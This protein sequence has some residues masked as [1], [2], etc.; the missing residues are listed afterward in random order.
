MDLNGGAPHTDAEEMPTTAAALGVI[1]ETERRSMMCAQLAVW[2]P[3]CSAD[4]IAEAFH[5]AYQRAAAGDCDATSVGQVY[6]WLRITA[7]RY[8]QRQHDLLRFELPVAPDSKPLQVERYDA[9]PFEQLAE[10]EDDRDL[11][12]LAERVVARLSDRQQ[13][14]FAL[15]LAGGTRSEIA[16]QLG[17]RA[18]V[19]KRD[20]ERISTVARSE[21]ANMAGGGC[22]DG[23]TPVM[24]L[25]YGLAETE[26]AA[27][28]RTHMARCRDCTN[29]YEQLDL[30][31][32]KAA[33]IL[34]APAAE[35]AAPGL[36]ERTVYGATDGAARAKQHVADAAS[37]LRNGI[38]DGGAQVKQQ[39]ASAYYRAV[40]P[41]P[42]AGVRP[43]AAA[44]VI[45]GCLAI[46][47]GAAT[48]CASEDFDPFG[49]GIGLVKPAPD[50]E[51]PTDR[52]PSAKDRSDPAETVAAPVPT[53]AP[54]PAPA[55]PAADPAPDPQAE[56]EAEVVP[57]TAEPQP[58][59]PSGSD[60]LSGLTGNPT[61]A[62]APAPPPAP[63]VSGNGGGG[64]GSAGTDFGGL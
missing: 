35:T 39:A 48:Y 55:A 32:Q 60:S 50:H 56:T 8:L 31:R 24:R 64:S 4:E 26:Q 21:L 30:W 13:R 18:R 47:G 45:V 11:A 6:R 59:P 34:P 28:A 46:G 51:K 58:V 63:T 43:G 42:L 27:E 3:Q 2:H 54:D 40:D 52:P 22:V 9:G 12:V 7:H 53:P 37:A 57:E 25:A 61:P 33:A 44:T 15:H 5:T 17:I 62:P 36:V 41:T 10:R 23:E 49:A 38:A 16:A 20:L 1:V 19:V 29:L 14:V